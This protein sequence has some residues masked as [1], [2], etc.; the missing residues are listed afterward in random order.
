MK[1]ILREDVEKLGK[2]GDIV[3]VADGFG[4][5]Y[6]IP[7]QMAVPADVR[8]LKALE[9]DRRVIEA[10][11]RK[12]RKTAESLAQRL[13]AVSLTLP[14]KAGEEGKLFGAITS[15][16]IAVALEAAGVPVD[17]KAILLPD[18]IKQLGDYKVK[19]KA[20]TDVV[21]EISVSV[22]AES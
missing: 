15:R 5:N 22:V 18:P 2:A 7:K 6:L 10:R 13:A 17:R 12:L 14:A 1:V 20:G 9:H 4:R 19:I 11:T 3:K 16:D 21:P 8:N